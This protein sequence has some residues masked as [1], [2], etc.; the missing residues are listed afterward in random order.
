MGNDKAT[1]VRVPWLRFV[2]MAVFLLFLALAPSFAWPSG[3]AG[4]NWGIWLVCYL[5][6]VVLI[7]WAVLYVIL[8]EKGESAND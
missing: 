8:S 2:G 3:P 5:S 1:R 6:Y 7:A 4:L